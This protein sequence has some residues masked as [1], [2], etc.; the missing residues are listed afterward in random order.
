MRAGKNPVTHVGKLY[1]IL[2]NQIADD[3]VKMGKGDILE[4]QTRILSQIGKPI[5]DPQAASANVIYANNVNSSKYEKEVRAI[6]DGRLANIT[7][8]TEEIVTGKVTVF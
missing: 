2:A 4:V 5:D 1:N 8:L 7:D 6:I 3:I